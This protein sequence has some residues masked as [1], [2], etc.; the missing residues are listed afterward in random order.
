MIREPQE[1]E[2]ISQQYVQTRIKMWM[3][4]AT[5]VYTMGV[6]QLP[7]EYQQIIAAYKFA[8]GRRR[9]EEMHQDLLQAF[10][11]YAFIDKRFTP[12]HYNDF[13]FDPEIKIYAAAM[14]KNFFEVNMLMTFL[15]LKNCRTFKDMCLKHLPNGYPDTS[16][17]HMCWDQ[18]KSDEPEHRG[19]INLIDSINS[20]NNVY[21]SL[22]GVK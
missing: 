8:A 1:I 2:R 22:Y 4:Y 20:V 17:L 12:Q 11:A 19:E 6:R 21:E 5:T 15:Y 9:Q 16:T 3:T 13:V 10:D 7:I 18:Q 14:C